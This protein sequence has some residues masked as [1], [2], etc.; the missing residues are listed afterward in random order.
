M[1]LCSASNDV[2]SSELVVMKSR[3]RALMIPEIISQ[4][5]SYLPL[6][7]KRFES[8]LF[9]FVEYWDP[10]H[11][12]NAGAVCRM[13]HNVL[14]P[15]LWKTYDLA[16]MEEK[17]PFDVLSRNIK[18]VRSVS[19]LDQK[20]R[21]NTALWNALAEHAHINRLE[22]HDAV[23]P[24]KRLLGPK[25]HT[26]VDLKLSGN[27]TRMH[28]FLLIFVE[29]QVFLESL[30]LTRLEFTASDWK[31]I[32]S[33]KSHIRKLVI[34]RRC[35]FLDYKSFKTEEEVINVD[36]VVDKKVI[37]WEVSSK[38]ATNT[39]VIAMDADKT[40]TIGTKRKSDDD[41]IG[42]RPIKKGVRNRAKHINT[43]LPNA[44]NLGILP[45]THLVLRDSQLL[46]P[47]QQA[48]LEAC[49]DLEQLDICYTQK[50]DG[51]IVAALIRDSCKK[52][53]RLTLRSTRQ[54]WTLSMIDEMPP[55]VTEL[56]LHTGQLDKQITT[57]IID[58]K[59][60][61]TRLELDFGQEAKGKRRLGCILSILRECTE[62]REF[63]YHN[64][65]DDK[66]FQDIL[67]KKPWNL[68]NLRKLYVHGV[69]PRSTNTGIT[70]VPVPDGWRQDHSGRRSQCCD[71]RSFED[72]HKQG[73]I[74][75]SL[76]FDAALL[77]HVKDLP[78]LSEIVITE[79]IYHKKLN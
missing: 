1:A 31:R 26:L 78:S 69:G 4:I 62:L 27:C 14:T 21:K 15:L 8:G 64:H 46:L 10:K 47:F 60:I 52:V 36:E 40:S 29:R 44:K 68:P 49:P 72:I 24:V 45:I 17:V 3:D 16:I 79:A 58:R 32:L 43:V 70:Q 61:L 57:A 48:M 22:I 35:E 33:N 5:G 41:G 7:Q 30:E 51:G 6:F 66:F 39:M 28:P 2:V 42:T 67:F 63:A 9:S 37:K 73:P 56:I 11:L 55:S 54:P 38:Q 12:L 23:F 59:D 20:H 53:R 25:A 74:L 75:N 71:A 19:L 34:D 76:M 65:A 77:D 18:H 50:A 13:W